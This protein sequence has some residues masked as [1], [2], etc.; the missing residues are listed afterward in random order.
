VAKGITRHAVLNSV[1]IKW[2]QTATKTSR[3]VDV[4]FSSVARVVLWEVVAR[5]P[6]QRLIHHHEITVPTYGVDP[7]QRITKDQAW[8][9]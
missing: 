6:D 5:A 2:L 7:G 3:Y 1:V 8:V 4:V 9:H